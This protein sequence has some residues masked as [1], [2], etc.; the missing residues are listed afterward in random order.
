MTWVGL[1]MLRNDRAKFAA[2]IVAVS[3]AVFLMQNQAAILATM[4]SMTAAQIRDVQDA[5]LWVTQPEVEC[6]DQVRS[7]R[8]I[9][10]LRVRGVP[11][12]A[13]AAPLVKIDAIGRSDGGRLNT[14]S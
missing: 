13:W 4:L 6:F 8:D 12:V 14:L 1:Q 9:E 3:L 5:D 7:L 10:L 11:G 2:M